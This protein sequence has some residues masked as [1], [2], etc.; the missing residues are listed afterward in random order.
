MIW[1]LWTINVC[2]LRFR[3]YAAVGTS[4]IICV[5]YNEKSLVKS[6]FPV[7]Y[8]YCCNRWFRALLLYNTWLQKYE[9][10]CPEVSLVLRILL[11]LAHWQC[12]L[13]DH[14]KYSYRNRKVDSPHTMWQ[15]QIIQIIWY[16]ISL[17]YVHFI[18]Y[19]AIYPWSLP[20]WHPNLDSHRGR[21]Q[22]CIFLE[23]YW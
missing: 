17:V 10:H 12:L 20:L 4:K 6:F 5:V 2:V 18:F 9:D 13:R 19:T 7:K 21:S 8:V 15:H 23:Q 14:T 3:W 1:T 22:L 11:W 16:S